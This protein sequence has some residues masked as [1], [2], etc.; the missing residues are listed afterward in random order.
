MWQQI[1]SVFV[2]DASHVT[3]EFAP[4]ADAVPLVPQQGYLRVWLVEGYLA[5]ARTWGN[6]HFPALH[7]GAALN[8]AGQSMTAFAQ[9]NR[10][11]EAITAPGAQLNFALT[12]SLPYEGGPVEVEAALFR[13]TAK[14]PLGAAA[15]LVGALA[16][17][18]GPPLA[19]AATLTDR[20]STGLDVI[21]KQA[22]DGPVLAVHQSFTA[23]RS[24]YLVV[25]NT[26]PGTFGRVSF[27]DGLLHADTGAGPQRPTGTDF[28]VLHVDCR[29][30]PERWRLA[31]F[32][33]LVRAAGT[34][35]LNKQYDTF[36]ALRTEAVIAAWNCTDFVPADRRRI[37]KFLAEEIDEVK[38]L[39]AVARTAQ[40]LDDAAAERMPSRKDPEVGT[41]RLDDLL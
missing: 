7:G 35:Y 3:V 6:D 14:G 30:E 4:L 8:F 40:A 23:V 38:E 39:G 36:K 13:T 41:L 31:H 28:L 2:A 32:D 22:D 26:P 11:P 21:M 25:A 16:P 17:L 10:A 34:A 27:P 29:T 1:K 24:G 33:E 18:L 37:A 20:V 15:D 5:R 19:A 9:F 12:P